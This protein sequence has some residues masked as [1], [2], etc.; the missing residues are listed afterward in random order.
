MKHLWRVIVRAWLTAPINQRTDWEQDDI[1]TLRLY[2]ESKSGK[3]FLQK[4][5]ESAA[6]V[7][8]ASVYAPNTQAV[9][10]AAYARGWQDS[11]ALVYRLSRV[12][13]GAVESEYGVDGEERKR[14]IPPR[15]NVTGAQSSWFG[16]IGGGS[17][18]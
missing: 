9:S 3:R 2:L 4:L 8:F 16:Q 15:G 7:S 14:E 6:D 12:F 1:E 10:A 17:A 18:L 13:P 5:R 11:L